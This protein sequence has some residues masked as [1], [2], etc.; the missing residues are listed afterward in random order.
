[1]NKWDKST[2]LLVVGSGSGG[3]TAAVTAKDQGSNVIVIEKGELYGGS[4]SMSGGAIWVPCNYLMQQ[5][6][7]QD[8]PEEALKYLKT[9]TKDMVSEDRLLAYID[10][11]PKMVKYLKERTHVRFK[12]VP[13]YS[14][15]YPDVEGSRAEGGRT[16]E[17]EPLDARGLGSMWNEL[18]PMPTQAVVFGRILLDAY[19][20]HEMFDTSLKGRLK[21][22]KILS[23]YFLNP[24]RLFSKN[25]TH[26]TLGGALIG[27][28]RLS[29]A[30]RGIPIWMNTQAKKLILENGRVVGIEARKSGRMIR[31]NSK[32]G[33]I[34]AA[35][36]FEHNKAMREKYQRAPVSDEWTIGNP[37]NTGDAVLMGREIGAGLGF[38]DEAWWMST[39]PVPGVETPYMVLVDRTL[40]GSIIVNTNGKRFTNEA[41]PYI[42]VVND[43]HACH[44]EEYSAVPAFLIADHR[45]HKKYPLGAL[46]PGASPRKYI[47]N[48]FIKA[49]DTLEELAGKCGIDP[50]GLDA[51]VEKFN[52]FAKTGKDLD[53]KRG[54]KAIDR[55]YSDPSVKP[56]PCL[57]PLDK[58]PFYAMEIFPGDLGTKGGLSTDAHA[59][60]LRE[61]GT[62]IHG[63]YATG[64]CSSPIMG[65]TYP[66]AGGTIGPSMTFGYIAAL[67]AAGKGE[68]GR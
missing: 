45:F 9:I 16:I 57:A 17:P 23:A 8:Y 65:A 63:L 43:Q 19:E 2:D 30:E 48:G 11:A 12:L 66:G 31:I 51:E 42:D 22:A 6:G 56:N 26:L 32:K 15:Y 4:S 1:M 7:I 40:P 25:D 35:G 46:M 52:R 54:D 28:L 3:M 10:S 47:A 44:S 49:A 24:A 60:V 62:P 27:R 39:T 58:P 59:R 61:D 50:A 53:F 21:A 41:G 20:F 64:N 55:Y 67:H 13:G 38:M 29:L 5:A 37:E 33:V 34:L 36:G 14:D 68:P 18:R